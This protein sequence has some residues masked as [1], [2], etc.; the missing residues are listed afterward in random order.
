MGNFSRTRLQPVANFPGGAPSPSG[1]VWNRFVEFSSVGTTR[2]EGRQESSRH[3][4]EFLGRTRFEI[5]HSIVEPSHGLKDNVECRDAREVLPQGRSTRSIWQSSVGYTKGNSTVTCAGIPRTWEGSSDFTPRVDGI[6]QLGKGD[7][8]CALRMDI[9]HPR[10]VSRA[11][12]GARY[13]EGRRRDDPFSVWQR[14]N[15]PNCKHLT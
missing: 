6:V 4:L 14:K 8:N 7:E 12:D 3:I 9:V 15:R 13:R 5:D 2:W 1:Q 11:D 10:S